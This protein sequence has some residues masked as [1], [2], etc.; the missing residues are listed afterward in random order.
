MGNKKIIFQTDK[1]NKK[2]FVAMQKFK[3][4]KLRWWNDCAEKITV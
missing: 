3:W 4:T 1:N 2:R